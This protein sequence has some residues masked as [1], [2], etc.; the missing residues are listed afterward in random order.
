[1]DLPSAASR[2][3]QATGVLAKNL[4]KND[5]DAERSSFARTPYCFTT[6]CV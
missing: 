4:R 3:D 6:L 2:G 5:Q 1:M